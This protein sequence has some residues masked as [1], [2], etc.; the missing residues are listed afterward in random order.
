MMPF[1]SYLERDVDFIP[2]NMTKMPSTVKN[3]FNEWTDDRFAHEIENEHNQSLGSNFYHREYQ[4]YNYPEIT[5]PAPRRPTDLQN[6]SVILKPR[7]LKTKNTSSNQQHFTSSGQE[8]YPHARP[9]QLEISGE[10]R[11]TGYHAAHAIPSEKYQKF[12]APV[13][14]AELEVTQPE[15]EHEYE[16]Q[17]HYDG[18]LEMQPRLPSNSYLYDPSNAQEYHGE[19]SVEARRTKSSTPSKRSKSEPRSMN[20]SFIDETAMRN[21]GESGKVVSIPTLL[22]G[23]ALKI[24]QYKT[25]PYWYEKSLSRHQSWK[26]IR[27][28]YIAPRTGADRSK[29]YWADRSWMRKNVWQEQLRGHQNKIVQI[30]SDHFR[31]DPNPVYVYTHNKYTAHGGWPTVASHVAGFRSQPN[32]ERS[33][34]EEPRFRFAPHNNQENTAIGTIGTRVRV[35]Q[36]ERNVDI[37]ASQWRHDDRRSKSRSRSG[38]EKPV[39]AVQPVQ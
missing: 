3:Q 30:T 34:Q 2:H 8:R 7:H 39:S 36:Q 18:Y 29:P 17:K 23:S 33:G 13:F 11:R 5:A 31:A 21:V 32:L 1:Y 16:H 12:G 28:P 6:S 14:T 9:L 10:S 4:H 37:G 19:G 22:D 20:G 26:N 24:K 25:I 35:D 15:F 38:S 27:D